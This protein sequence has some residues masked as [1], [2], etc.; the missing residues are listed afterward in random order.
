MTIDPRTDDDLP[1]TLDAHET[2]YLG[3]EGTDRAF[4]HVASCRSGVSVNAVWS[5][6]SLACLSDHQ[7][8]ALKTTDSGHEKLPGDGHEAARWRT[9]KTAR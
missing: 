4:F 8:A 7:R 3:I 6:S 1:S 2:V 5:T 9:L